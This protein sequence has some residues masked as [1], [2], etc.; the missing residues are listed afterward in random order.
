[1][2]QVAGAIE[3]RK[4]RQEPRTLAILHG[5]VPNQ[6]DA[7]EYTRE[8]LSE[9]YTH[10]ITRQGEMRPAVVPQK[11]LLD[12]VAGE[13]E[14]PSEVW[15]MI[16]RY[17]ESARLLGQRTGELHVVLASAPEDPRFCPEAFSKLYQ[18][19]LYQSTRSLTGRVFQLLRHTL[20]RLPEDVKPGAKK[21][22]DGE[23]KVMERFLSVSQK[24]VSAKRLR[25]HGDFHLGQVLWTGMD[26]VIMDF[27]GEPA[28]P[29]NERRIKRS[30]L[31]DVAG[32][33]RSFHYAAYSGLLEF[34]ER[35]GLVIPEELEAMDSW[36]LFW[37]CWVCVIFLKA[38]MEAATGGGFLPKSREELRTLLDMYL[39]EKAIYEMGYEL[40]NRPAW[41]RIPLRGIL[42]L[43]ES[44]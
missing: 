4:P 2:P 10:A 26:F 5:F 11:H 41:V 9:Y 43:L 7:W 16:G 38:Y 24:K 1:M 23:R 12:L 44:P 34:R 28:R 17:A 31:R 14:I 29:V 30:P 21:V 40:N 8:S 36:A 32:M 22:L 33:L 27:E 3:Y 25:C 42:Q 18:R 13:E 37:Q 19:S 6:G 35:R 20:P 15:D 39:L